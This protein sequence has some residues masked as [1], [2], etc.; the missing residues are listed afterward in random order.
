M[1]DPFRLDGPTLLNI[2]GGRT[3]A[4][5]LRRVLDAHDGALPDDA[6]AVFCNTGGEHAGTLDFLDETARQWA[7]ALLRALD[8]DGGGVSALSQLRALVLPLASAHA[9]EVLARPWS[10][11]DR[12]RVIR[13]GDPLGT[14]TEREAHADRALAY[15]MAVELYPHRS[16]RYARWAAG[17]AALATDEATVRALGCDPALREE[18]EG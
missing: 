12:A 9:R 8:V 16:E 15:T 1:G 2:S 4:L 6:H 14:R 5:M 11:A 3:S 10:A 13:D 18:I 7:R 17:W